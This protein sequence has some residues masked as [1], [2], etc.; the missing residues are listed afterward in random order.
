MD[1]VV[2]PNGAA[3][4]GGRRFHRALGR[5][6]I[7]A[8]KREGDGATPAGTL[9]LTRVLYRPDRVARPETELP[10]AALRRDDGWCDAPNDTA[11]NLPV[12]LPHGASAE[13]M[14]RDDRVYDLV[15]ITDHN[16]GPVVPGRGSAI[17]VHVATPDFAATEGC[18]A[19]SLEDLRRIVGEWR[20]DDRIDVRAD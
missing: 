1:L 5:S 2:M 15:V 7:K 14:W 12:R 17:F 20:P 11:Y 9:A 18:I 4:W 19:F 13:A 3:E 10:C 8:D 16:T 6:G